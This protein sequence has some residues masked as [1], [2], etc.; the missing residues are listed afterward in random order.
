MVSDG[1]KM[2]ITENIHVS[3]PIMTRL[4]DYR[5]SRLLDYVIII[6]VVIVVVLGT[7][8]K[9]QIVTSK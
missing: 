4:L 9:K 7:P 8:G 1:S 5:T 6:I 2:P 3:E